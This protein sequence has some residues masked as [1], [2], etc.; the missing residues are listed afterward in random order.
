MASNKITIF[1]GDD[2][3][4]TFT[5]NDS[6][7]DPVDITD[8]T[9]FFTV[10]TVVNTTAAGSLDS[11]AVIQKINGPGDHS[12]PTI[13]KTTFSLTHADTAILPKIY[14]YDVQ[15][16]T[17]ADIVTTF[18]VAIFEITGEVTTDITE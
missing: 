11:T 7:G 9:I 17:A 3:T 8:D 18:V 15:W 5:I 13:G 1:R 16:V 2:A 4:F 10:K 14:Y 12:D 6:D